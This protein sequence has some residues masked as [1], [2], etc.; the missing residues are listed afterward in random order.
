[1]GWAES[2][3]DAKEAANN[4]TAITAKGSCVPVPSRLKPVS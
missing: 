1:M 4:A 2:E 3:Q